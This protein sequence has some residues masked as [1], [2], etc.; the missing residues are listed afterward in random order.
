M[1]SDDAASLGL[2]IGAAGEGVKRGERESDALGVFLVH[3]ESGI[4]EAGNSAEYEAGV[5]RYEPRDRTNC[6]GRSVA[7]VAEF[8][9]CLGWQDGHA[10]TTSGLREFFGRAY[11]GADWLIQG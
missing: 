5:E 11:T 8:P 7:G 4:E 3:A 10:C 9:V 6:A 2:A 1:R